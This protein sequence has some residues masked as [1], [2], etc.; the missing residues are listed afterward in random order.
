MKFCFSALFQIFLFDYQSY[1]PDHFIH[2][3][4]TCYP[5]IKWQYH[6]K[7]GKF[8]RA[9]IL[10]KAY[11][12]PILTFHTL[13]S[14]RLIQTHACLSKL[15]IKED[16]VKEQSISVLATGIIE[17]MFKLIC[18]LKNNNNLAQLNCHTLSVTGSFANRTNP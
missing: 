11:M 16:H 1:I 14:K 4:E 17:L 5:F 7:Q 6:E 13:I 18:H 8:A 10:R 9:I 3:D 2:F 15:R 12:Q